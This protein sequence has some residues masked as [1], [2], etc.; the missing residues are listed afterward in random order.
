MAR[1]LFF[2]P[3]IHDGLAEL[4]GE[5]ARHLSKVLRVEPGQVY[6]ISDNQQRYLAA[7]DAVHKEHVSFRVIEPLPT[8]PDACH[9]TLAMALVKFDRLEWVLE[10]ATELGVHRIVPFWCDRSENGL[11][12]AAGKRMERWRKI[13]IE[14]AQQSR[15]TFLPLVAEPVALETALA[16]DA[17][18]RYFLDEVPADA[19]FAPAKSASAA[20]VVGPEGGWTERERQAALRAGWQAVGLG[21]RILRAETAALAALAILGNAN[22]R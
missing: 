2:L 17:Q 22:L 9:L 11:E 7:V 10:K 5:E 15:R 20:M 1:R 8:V 21:P 16:V 18:A 19:V 14:S 6:E 3:E 12:K 13:L 4:R